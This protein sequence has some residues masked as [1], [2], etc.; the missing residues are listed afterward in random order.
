MSG[1]PIQGSGETPWHSLTLPTGRHY[2]NAAPRWG[3]THNEASVCA[4]PVQPRGI[5]FLC[6]EM[7]QLQLATASFHY[8]C[9]LA[10]CTEKR[11]KVVLLQS[12]HTS[13]AYRSCV[14][15]RGSNHEQGLLAHSKLSRVLS[16]CI[17]IP[18]VKSASAVYS[19][20]SHCPQFNYM[21]LMVTCS[22]RFSY[23]GK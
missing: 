8:I 12:E 21:A 2:S 20:L 4:A 3:R 6:F 15:R 10:S 19:R 18:F 14:H 11:T 22:F 16:L 9:S 13:H 5:H 23:A 1:Q 17:C 7:H